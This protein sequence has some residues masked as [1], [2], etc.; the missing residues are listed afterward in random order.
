M[1]VGLKFT[2]VNGDGQHTRNYKR[3]FVQAA[4]LTLLYC[5][6]KCHREPQNGITPEYTLLKHIQNFKKYFGLLL[7]TV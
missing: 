7:F 4:V 5:I 3:V 2:R 1:Q 6:P